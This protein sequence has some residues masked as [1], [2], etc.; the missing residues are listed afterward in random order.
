ML[1]AVCEVIN[2]VSLVDEL[3]VLDLGMATQLILTILACDPALLELLW[4]TVQEWVQIADNW[5]V[6][7]ALGIAFDVWPQAEAV[8]LITDL[9]QNETLASL[10]RV[11]LDFDEVQYERDSNLVQTSAIP[12]FSIERA[13]DLFLG[14]LRRIS[15]VAPEWAAGLGIDAWV[16]GDSS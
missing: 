15:L 13:L 1:V 11:E 16:A 4:E 9:L 12:V 7:C 14:L 10:A 8:E 5:A 3:V 6:A 2:R